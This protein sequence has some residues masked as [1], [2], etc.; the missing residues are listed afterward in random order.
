[1]P[2]PTLISH[3]SSSS[4][5]TDPV[6]MPHE[7]PA[8]LTWQTSYVGENATWSEADPSGML[9]QHISPQFEAL[10]S[11]YGYLNQ[12]TDAYLGQWS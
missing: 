5:S 2:Y 9:L 8:S 3:S 6:P 11:G 7:H 4:T 10:D 12:H 1:M